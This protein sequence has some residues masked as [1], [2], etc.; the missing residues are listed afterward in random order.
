M[1]QASYLDQANVQAAAWGDYDNDGYPDLY[2]TLGVDN[3]GQADICEGLQD[4]AAIPL[5][6]TTSEYP[7]P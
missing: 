4:L 7:V 6:T 3:G 5:D 2:V 1:L